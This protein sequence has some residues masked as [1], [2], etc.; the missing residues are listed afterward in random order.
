MNGTVGS[1]RDFITGAAWMGAV[2]VAAGCVDGRCL[3]GSREGGPMYGFRV[4]PMRRIR[5]GFVGVGGR[6]YGAVRR[7]ALI[8][9]CEITA[10]CDINAERV[11][12]V[13]KFLAE[14]GKPAAKEFGRTADD[15][16]RLCDLDDVDVVYSCTPREMHGEVNV[17]GLDAGKHV[18]Q[19]VPGVFTV[20]EA[21]ATVE[22]AERNRRHCMMLENCCYGE[23]E[24]LAFNLVKQGVLGEIM[25]AE[26]A[27]IHDQRRFQYNPGDGVFWRIDRHLKH[28]GNYYPTHGMV[29]MTK[30]M[31]VNRG[32]RF[33]YLVSME[34]ASRAFETYAQSAFPASDRRYHWKMVRGDVNNILIRTA[35]GKCVFVEHDVSSPRPY[36]RGDLLVGTK[37]TFRAYP[38]LMLAFEDKLGDGKAHQYFSAERLQEV[39]EK[40]MHPLWREAGKAAREIEAKIGGHGG[41]DFVMDLRWVYCLQNGLPL[42]TNVY[43]LATWSSVVELSERSVNARSA[44]VDFPDFTRGAWK[45]AKP[46]EVVTVDVAKM[47]FKC[48]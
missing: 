24:L 41:M 22:A 17:Y 9:G 16:K 3:C 38:S 14:Q 10:V 42:D 30:A 32:D 23:E 37:G 43:D 21:W 15:W 29:P 2:A 20:E 27:Y 5:I 26:C 4:A 1:R 31:D 28:H 47:G 7:L 13:R 12:R 40:Y 46:F 25:Q 19:E 45:T 44:A 11:A 8:P 36:S 6:G 18:L 39:R 33:E 34:T 48:A 35:K